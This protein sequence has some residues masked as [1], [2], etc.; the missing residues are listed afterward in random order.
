MGLGQRSRRRGE[1][2]LIARDQDEGV[3]VAGELLGQSPADALRR[4]GND[5]GRSERLP[6][7]GGIV[8]SRP[9]PLQKGRK[10]PGFC[11]K[12]GTRTVE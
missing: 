7:F 1:L 11:A 9:R 6:P 2:L 4:P 5:D 8:H 3:P 12:G 10:G